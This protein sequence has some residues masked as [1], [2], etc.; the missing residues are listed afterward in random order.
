[1]KLTDLAIRRAVARPKAYTLTPNTSTSFRSGAQI[2]SRE[3][4]QKERQRPILICFSTNAHPIK[5]VIT[6]RK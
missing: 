1:M 6:M 2:S 5:T 3:A 4:E